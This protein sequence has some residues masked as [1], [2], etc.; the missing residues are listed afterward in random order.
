MPIRPKVH[1]AAVDF[2]VGGRHFSV[3]DIVDG[4]A[5]RQVLVFGDLFVST[6]TPVAKK[7]VSDG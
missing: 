6:T 3:G 1:T 7:E 2:H 5:L 4:L